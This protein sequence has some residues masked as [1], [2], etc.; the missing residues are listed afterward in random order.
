[1]P[2]FTAAEQDW[3]AYWRGYFLKWLEGSSISSY[4]PGGNPGI[5][6]TDYFANNRY[7]GGGAVCMTV[8]GRTV[9]A[10]GFGKSNVTGTT[11]M[12]T[13]DTVCGTRS[14][15]KVFT[16]VVVMKMVEEGRMSL[17]QPIGDFDVVADN[18]DSSNS[19]G[20]GGNVKTPENRLDLNATIRH[21]LTHTCGN[22][23]CYGW[24]GDTHLANTP[25]ETVRQY[26]YFTDNQGELG[27]PFTYLDKAP[28][29]PALCAQEAAQ[30][31]GRTINTYYGMFA[32]MFAAFGMTRS[33]P[34]INWDTR[35]V[36]NN[37]W[38]A[39]Q[40]AAAGF[41]FGWRPND[42]AEALKEGSGTPNRA[43]ELETTP[44]TVERLFGMAGTYSTARDIC[45][46]LS[47][48]ARPGVYLSSQYHIDCI[49]QTALGAG[50]YG[51]QQPKDGLHAQDS[52][53]N[54]PTRRWW[55]E[56]N[57][58][59][60]GVY[61][62]YKGWTVGGYQ[63][64]DIAGRLTHG[65]VG[66]GGGGHQLRYISIPSLDAHISFFTHGSSIN[67]DGGGGGNVDGRYNTASNTYVPGT[68]DPGHAATYLST[69]PDMGMLTDW[70]NRFPP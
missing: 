34:A 39:Q 16:A 19:Y 44:L 23:T 15:N 26:C 48:I 3:R 24:L 49:Q 8:G 10:E 7:G 57:T 67:R 6:N 33:Y 29:I 9:F 43:M 69:A 65:H 20:A 50:Y 46:F 32:E 4:A 38:L 17:D 25:A 62:P 5:I 11:N 66:G 31:T 55:W 54:N 51:R 45:T 58:W 63:H 36:N 37:G 18:Y 64:H 60:N 61:I 41:A 42:F 53:E 27:L 13:P 12:W 68:S 21:Y 70:F 40:C 47:K 2:K 22:G 30:K 1:L 59:Y 52:P 14:V 56:P 35:I 28:M